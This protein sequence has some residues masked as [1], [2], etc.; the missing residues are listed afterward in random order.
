[1]A[2]TAQFTIGAEASCS[3]GIQL[4]ITRQE[5]EDLPPVD[6]GHPGASAAG[7]RESV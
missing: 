4:T 6:A 3:D 1:M 7:G 2:E 5:V